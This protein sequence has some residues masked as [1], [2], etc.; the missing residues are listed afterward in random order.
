MNWH[1]FFGSMLIIVGLLWT[2]SA[3]DAMVKDKFDVNFGANLVLLL[4]G[5]II[6][7]CGYG[8]LQ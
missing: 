8:M 1:N 7:A 6:A 3:C 4:I 5:I 2:V